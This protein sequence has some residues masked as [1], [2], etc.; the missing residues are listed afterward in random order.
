MN[1]EILFSKMI[2]DLLQKDFKQVAPPGPLLSSLDLLVHSENVYGLEGPVGIYTSYFKDR[3]RLF[4]HEIDK[5]LSKQLKIVQGQIEKLKGTIRIPNI[6]I[7]TNLDDEL[8]SNFLES[9]EYTSGIHFW[10]TE[11]IKKLLGKHKSILDKYNEIFFI[12]KLEEEISL[13]IKDHSKRIEQINYNNSKNISNLRTAFFNRKLSLFLGAGVSISAGVPGWKDLVSKVY[14]KSLHSKGISLGELES[15][16][17]I[18]WNITE[19]LN[20]TNLL[21]RTRYSKY[22]L[23]ENYKNFVKEALY[24]NSKFTSDL[25]KSIVTLCGNTKGSLKGIVTYNF[26]DLLEQNLKTHNIKYSSI[27]NANQ[28]PDSESIP[29]FHVHGF[30]PHDKNIE[31]HIVFSEDDYHNLYTDIYSWSNLIQINYFR[32]YNCF[33]IG[34]SLLDP[35]IRRL[36]DIAKKTSSYKKH[37]VIQK[38]IYSEEQL[39]E[40]LNNIEDINE[41]FPKITNQNHFI[42]R[43]Y[44]PII[45]NKDTLRNIMLTEELL[46][47]KDYESL[48]IKVIWVDSFDDIVKV[49][50]SIG[51]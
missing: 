17:Q 33:F 12:G 10:G 22:L 38:R 50:N 32:D 9:N 29:I 26:D 21:I 2:Q 48:G 8:L 20:S 19:G 34:T 6:I 25:I 3:D 24:E 31:S 1:L 23:N 39:E 30:I 28:I 27:W 5:V 47:E 15:D 45:A 35:N 18:Y 46:I 42:K 16:P 44:K 7:F 11:K 4:S 41:I 36:L 40:I 13:L 14:L 49:I 43:K 37:Y 51:G